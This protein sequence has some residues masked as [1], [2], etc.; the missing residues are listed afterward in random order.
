MDWNYIAGF[1]DG[2]GNIS[3]NIIRK[4]GKIRGLQL[5]CRMYN[6]NKEVLLK[7]KEFLGYGNIYENKKN[8][9][10]WRLV[11]E[12]SINCK[13]NVLSFLINIK[14]IA[15]IKKEQIQFVLNNYHFE[16]NNNFCFDVDKLRSFNKRLNKGIFT[17]NTNLLIKRETQGLQAQERMR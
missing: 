14:D 6:S 2:E 5:A 11:Y 13:K 9:F 3:I 1:F 12:L 10:N 8:S 15:Y 4:K 16:K 17:K 7:I